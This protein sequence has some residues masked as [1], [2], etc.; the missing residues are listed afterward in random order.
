MLISKKI[1]NIE[2]SG[3]MQIAAKAIELKKRGEN[4]IDLTVGEPDFPTPQRIKDA[5][6]KALA[7]DHT[8]YTLNN[9][10]S[11]LRSAIS[12]RLKFDYFLDYSLDEI[13]VS[14]GA[15]HSIYNSI[16]TIIDEGDEVLIQSPYYVSYPQMVKLAGGIPRILNTSAE[17]EFKFTADQLSRSIT[18]KTKV[19]IL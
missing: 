19:I 10:I 17:S 8:K 1:N 7:D 11:E 14:N 12:D 4:V 13:I 9:G 3:T 5:A 2:F 6:V 18:Q 15:K 16:Q